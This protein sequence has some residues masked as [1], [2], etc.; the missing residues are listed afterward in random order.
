MTKVGLPSS[1]ME[2]EYPNSLSKAASLDRFIFK[3]KHCDITAILRSDTLLVTFDNLASIDERPTDGPWKPWLAD[4]AQALDFSILGMQ[5]H[6]KDWYRTPEPAEQIKT[7]QRH[8]FFDQFRNILF[9]GASMG[10]FAALCFASLVPEARVLAFSPQSTLN[11]EIAPFE[12][13]Y[14]WP[15]RKFDWETPAYLDA[16]E[17]VGAI[18]GGHVFYDPR[19]REDALHAQRLEAPA[20]QQ[21]RI[22]FADHTLI[23]TIAKCGALE[24]LIK[25]LAETGTLDTAFWTKMR[26]RRA[27]PLWAK[28]FLR[29][30]AARGDGPLARRACDMMSDTYGYPFA[31]R[32]RKRM[33]ATARAEAAERQDR[34][35][36]APPWIDG[37]SETDIRRRIPVFVNSYN[38]LTYLRDTVNWFAKHGFE[39]LRVLDNQSTF[40]DLQKYFDS[41]DFKSKAR[42]IALDD[43][44]GPRRSLA[45][46]AED[47]ATDG[48]F[49]FTDPDLA[50]PEPPAPDMVT[51]MF[52][53][54]LRHD[55]V[56][57]GL[58]LSIDPAIIDIDRVTYNTRTVQQVE[59]KYWKNAVE[60]G[61]FKATTDTTFFL[62]VPRATDNRRFNDYGTRQARIPSIRIGQEGFIAIH[63]PWLHKDQID[64]AEERFYFDNT[65]GH[66]TF[67]VAQKAARAGSK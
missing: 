29:A 49:I 19:V 46:A 48:G 8:G 62:Y 9:V 33:I 39:N 40:P 18:D 58:A 10:G 15:H 44:L 57:V 14:P 24:Q 61:V 28:L 43:N 25:Q 45:V 1:M 13:R 2:T 53:M 27:D 20:L 50:L 3:G 22:P 54:G 52:E 26:A 34:G 12:R 55:Y 37:L 64:P 67:V 59:N 5:S 23:R 30:A 32:I 36:P 38:Q 51:R 17:H 65:D 16:A 11:R 35:N 56:K 66:S 4:R 60:A 63:R 6:Q 31:R 21:V 47:T 7:L 42:L 41:E